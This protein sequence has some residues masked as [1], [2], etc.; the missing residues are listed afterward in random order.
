MDA[1]YAVFG[2]TGRQGSATASALLDRGAKVRAL[3]RNPESAAARSLEARGAE[4]VSVDVLR[5]ES[6]KR[7]FTGVAAAF[8][9]TAIAHGSEDEVALGKLIGRA[10]KDAE[11]PLLVFSSVGGAERNTGIPHF[12]SKRYIEEFL[13]DTVP[14]NI[15]R[16]VFFMEN[17]LKF[18]NGANGGLATLTMPLPDGIPLQMIASK[19]IGEVA[20]SQLLA[21]NPSSPPIEIGGDEL[22]GSQIARCVSCWLDKPTR[23]ISTSPEE[24]PDEDIKKMFKWFTNLPAYQA[25]FKRTR[26]LAPQLQNLEQWLTTQARPGVK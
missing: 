23:Y 17:L 8:A 10:A 24:L 21:R 4:V 7:A 16:P 15:I 20:S 18:I 25:D 9:M 6:L 11:L 13:V 5:P 2:S 19:D 1:E 12:E 22:T 14:V 26:E 3:T